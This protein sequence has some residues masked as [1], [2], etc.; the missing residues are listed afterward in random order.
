MDVR[1]DCKDMAGAG[2]LDGL[3][4]AAA[5]DASNRGDT[6]LQ[7]EIDGLAEE[8]EEG[9]QGE[10]GAPGADGDPGLSCWDLDGDGEADPDEDINDDGVWDAL[11]CQGADGEPGEPGQPGANCWDHVGDVNLDGTADWKDC[12]AYAED[13]GDESGIIASAVVDAYGDVRPGARNITG[14]YPGAYAGGNAWHSVGE[15]QVIIYLDDVEFDLNEVEAEDFA[16]FI[17]IRATSATQEPGGVISALVGHYRFAKFVDDG[18]PVFDRV[19]QTL[20]ME[21]FILRGLD[22]EPMSAE[23]SILIVE[24]DVPPSA[25]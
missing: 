19:S 9:G 23:F 22:G 17:T 4:F 13:G 11:D 15:Y 20:A 16:V 1:F 25:D 2:L 21:I 12:I 14:A 18:E 8:I 3:W 10:R 7:S 6:E 5:M 24:P